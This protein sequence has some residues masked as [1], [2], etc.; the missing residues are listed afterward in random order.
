MLIASVEQLFQARGLGAVIIG[1][2]LTS[3]SA[4]GQAP[5]S[6]GANTA[7]SSR[8]GSIKGRV[9]NENGEPLFNAGVLVR[10]FGSTNLEHRTTTDREGKFE[11]SGLEPVSYQVSAWFSAHISL[12][13]NLDNQQTNNYRIG[14][15]VTLVMTKGGVIT[16]TV[17][18]QTGEPLV[19]IYVRARRILEGNRQPTPYRNFVPVRRTDDRGIYRI[20]GLPP[21]TYVVWA[22]GGGGFYSAMD[23]YDTDVPTFSPSTTRDAAAEIAVRAGEEI[24]NVDIRYRGETGRVISGSVTPRETGTGSVFNISLTSAA[25]GGSTWNSTTTQPPDGGGFTFYG[26]DDG[27]YDVTARSL[28]TDGEWE[29]SAPQRIKVRGADVT[30]IQLVTRPLGSVRGRVVLEESKAAE[31]NDKRRPIFTET[32]VS[33]WHKENKDQPRFIWSLGVPVNADA[34]GNVTLRNLA[35][36]EYRFLAQFS[37]KYWYL[38]SISIAPR[39]TKTP[40]PRPIDA[41]RTWTSVKSGD[42]L[43]GLTLTLAQG[44]ASLRGQLARGEGETL[45]DGLFVYL[46]PAEREKADEVLRFFGAAVQPDGKIALNNLAPGRYWVLVQLASDGVS[47]PLTK[48][49]LPDE[50]ETRS[51]LRR[52]GEAAKNEIELKPCQDLVD[53]R[54]PLKVSVP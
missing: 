15:S 17:T 27:D 29:V 38:K 35:P 33:A 32:L 31:C 9:V 51:R 5:S 36:G 44:A 13:R 42:R 1:L 8:V 48:L 28:M 22:G 6:P 40:S 34:Q 43:S 18:T 41:G 3:S 23:A 19:G 7:Q 25:D 24:T 53:F 2:L 26:V 10:P 12:P 52:D 14:D 16:G 45:P 46:V 50:T 20:Y 30:G 49:R 39:V 4:V 37:A 54:L 21:G 11:V 47:S